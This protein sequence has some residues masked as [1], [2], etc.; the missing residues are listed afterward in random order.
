[1]AA[2]PSDRNLLFGVLALHMDL[3]ERGA[4]LAALAEWLAD[5]RRPIGEI[6]VARG[7]LT[8]EDRRRLE[9]L[10]DR[11]IAEHGGDLER[12]LAGVSSLGPLRGD[13][14]R[15]DD[16]DL[17]TSLLLI[18]PQAETSSP[19]RDVGPPSGAAAS[20][21]ARF[22]ILRMQDK[23]GMGVV[24]MAEDAEL[25]RQV[26][27]KE[28]KPE[29]ARDLGT[30]QRFQLEAEITGGLEHP[31]IVPVYGLGA[32]DDGRPYYVMRF[33]RGDS[34]K[35][36]IERFHRADES[37]GRD[38]TE[39]SLALRDL[40]QRFLDVCD[41]IAYAHQRGVL[42][43]DLKPGNVMVGRY[44]ETLV[45][46]WGLAKVLDRPEAPDDGEALRPPSASGSELTLQGPIGTLQFMSPEQAQERHERLG[47]ASDVYGL[48][49]TLYALL[50]GKPPRTT[51]DRV[52]LLAQAQ[53][54]EFTP[55]RVANPR[56]PAPLAAICERAMA[57]EPDRRYGSAEAL[58]DDVK[59]WL[60]DEPVSAWSEP[61]LARFGRWA[62]RH[63][64]LVAGLGA[65]LVVAV[66]ALSAGLAVLGRKNEELR[67]A[68]DAAQQSAE[69]AERR[70][71]ESKQLIDDWFTGVS[72]SREL[73]EAPG[74][75]PLRRK[76]LERAKDYYQQALEESGPSAELQT[77]AAA[78]S[79]RIGR[80]VGEIGRKPEAIEAH[81][82]AIALREPLARA[83]PRDVVHA[84][85]LAR[86]HHELARLLYENR[87]L[88]E[89]LQ[90]FEAARAIRQRISTERPADA[91][92]RSD[93]AVS[94]NAVG[95]LLTAVG[96]PDDALPEY[97]RSLALR[98]QAAR[99]RPDDPQASRDLAF[100][101]Q[102]LAVF[103]AQSGRSGEALPH[104]T[105]A[106]ELLARAAAAEPA[107]AGLAA[108]LAN[109]H[110][111]YALLLSMLGRRAEAI[112][113]YQRAREIQTRLALEN[114]AVDAYAY[115]LSMTHANLG[116]L[117]SDV[118]RGDEALRAYQD[119]AAVRERLVREHPSVTQYALT[120]ANSY[121]LLA[122]HFSTNNRLEEALEALDKAAPVAERLR[123]EQPGLAEAGNVVGSTHLNRGA[124]LAK[125]NRSDDALAAYDRSAGVYEALARSNPANGEYAS[126]HAKA[127][128]NAGA[129]LFALGRIDEALQRFAS[130]LAIRQAVAD[131]EP[132]I[133]EFQANLASSYDDLGAC[134][135]QL[136]HRDLALSA[137]RQ[138]EAIYRR[139]VEQDPDAAFAASGLARSLHHL[140]AMQADNG[141]LDEGLDVCRQALEIR[142][143]LA[144]ADP[145]VG[146]HASDLGQS[147]DAVGRLLLGLGRLEEAG[148]SLHSAWEIRRRLREGAPDAAHYAEQL[149]QT[150][151]N[152]ARLSL[153]RS[154]DK[155]ADDWL[156]RAQRSY[157]EA[158]PPSAAACFDVACVYCLLA[159]RAD[160]HGAGERSLDSALT[161][162][163][164]AARR[165]LR[166]VRRYRETEELGPL[167]ER[168]EWNEL[169]ESLETPDAPRPR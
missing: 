163:R 3:I 148:A 74:L 106:N 105:Q 80:I 124:V 61:A 23:G 127:L 12:S 6:L 64:T 155:E 11:R 116:I 137:H 13:L 104:F 4:L 159:R 89:A 136:G 39:R 117:L 99:E 76:L 24:W 62:R 43:R 98:E 109:G 110:H 90:E 21:S 154:Q 8:D 126:G 53:R 145:D 46:D 132:E 35:N 33:I 146:Q 9:Q 161:A 133:A 40:L 16:P 30:R 153:A 151:A 123:D 111:N 119:A 160:D 112:E 34:L 107:N 122:V 140:G 165:G 85:E 166:D 72:E 18:P 55:P 2:R 128:A 51:T 95:M 78:A 69:L 65:A 101:H 130:A 94:H 73:K 152:L 52:A 59:H 103:F 93:L 41:A 162:L 131:A 56:V 82:R 47:K 44:G 164:E 29:F 5:K 114:P 36:A 79:A 158:H 60:A 50:T 134:R 156:L 102:H 88:D 168:P 167:R 108:E 81:R 91:E 147:H 92:L 113:G 149:G 138:A 142:K 67:V 129:L 31:G 115:Q 66:A 144:D 75:Q 68:R 100:I 63:R 84:R 26:A 97:Q 57:P 54:G 14:Q 83:A 32:F 125:L 120:L 49:A 86:S 135:A 141:D 20:A 17:Q 96:R 71:R 143:R 42:H 150:Q 7:A 10:T 70:F 25:P 27:V 15:L 48:G 22:R 121:D 37:A 28:I 87:A 1:M 139:L 19:Q 38:P 58:A 157:A 169:M 45:V 77:D 118:G